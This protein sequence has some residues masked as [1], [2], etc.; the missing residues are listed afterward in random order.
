MLSLNVYSDRELSSAKNLTHL[1]IES[2]P[3]YRGLFWL[4][5]IGFTPQMEWVALKQDSN[6]KSKDKTV[7]RGKKG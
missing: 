6:P 1:T 3:A 5:Y 2:S 4:E 7:I